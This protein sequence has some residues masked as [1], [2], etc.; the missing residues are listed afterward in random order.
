[1]KM[2][3]YFVYESESHY[4]YY[5]YEDEK[6]FSS[7]SGRDNRS[8]EDEYDWF[9]EVCDECGYEPECYED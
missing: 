1:M 3:R 4:S 8:Y 2:P 6:V 5:V 7:E 9:T